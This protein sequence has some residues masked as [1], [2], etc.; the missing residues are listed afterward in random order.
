MNTTKTFM[1]LAALT[2]LFGTVGYAI[3]GQGGLIFA[4]VMAAGMNIFSYWNSDKIVLKMHGAQ[5]LS[6]H[7]IEDMTHEL[8]QRAG[9][10]NP[11]VYIMDTPQP[12]AFAT[13]RNP[14]NSAVAVT[15]GITEM[16]TKRELA[17]V[18]AHELAHI[19]N[20]DTLTMTV[21][22][23]IAGALSTVANFGRFMGRGR[24]RGASGNHGGN[25]IGMIAVVVLAPLAASI[26]QMAISRTREFSADKR[27]GEI[28]GDPLALASA[29]EKIQMAARGIPNR[30]AQ[31]NPA[32]AHMFIIPP[33]RKF[34]GLE[35]LFSTHPKTELRIEKLQAQ[36]NAL[37]ST[38]NNP[39]D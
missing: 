31:A 38:P 17:G 11:K 19:Q 12:N 7:W 4:L 5:P 25:G 21:T 2:A 9:L 22:A 18:I 10:P 34:P 26:V 15:R 6:G 36:A 27:G 3:G 30:R 28:C 8:A 13:G 14:E 33:L 37:D 39:W 20:R 32:S 35:M 23:T 29:L 16:L 24:G 1:L